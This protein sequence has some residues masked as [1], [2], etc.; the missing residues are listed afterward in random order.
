MGLAFP[1]ELL[2]L[3]KAMAGEPQEYA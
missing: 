1:K 2:A 3:Q